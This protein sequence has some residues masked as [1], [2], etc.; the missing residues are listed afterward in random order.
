MFILNIH[1]VNKYFQ[2]EQVLKD[3]TLD[4]EEGSLFG[5]LGPNGAGKTTLIRCIT[6]ILIPD[7]G[8]ITFNGEKLNPKHIIEMGYMPEERGLYKK[9]GVY[10]Q[11][12]YLSRLK[13]LSSK[14]AKNRIEFWL[15]KFKIEEWKNKKIEELSKGMGQKIQFIATVINTPKLLI[16]DEPFSGLDPVNADLIQQ[17]ILALN[18]KGTTII[19]STHRMEQVEQLCDKI[20][21]VNKGE[22]ILSGNVKEIIQENKKNKYK[23]T[24]SSKSNITL[25]ANLPCEILKINNNEFTFKLSKNQNINDVIKHLL[26]CN[27]TMTSLSEILPSIKEIFISKTTKKF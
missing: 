1:N 9:M 22:N 21:L 2:K 27:I 25:L 6:Q 10:E 24:F 13:G 7:S 5:F 12:L 8:K 3:I 26:D 17:E 23:I 4:I 11:L 18:K 15:E 14:E 20:V 16:L 19:F